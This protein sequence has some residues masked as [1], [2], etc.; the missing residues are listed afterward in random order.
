MYPDFPEAF[1]RTR[2]AVAL[3]LICV[4]TAA[5]RPLSGDGNDAA[6]KEA[7]RA[8]DSWLS[9]VDAGKY[10]ESWTDASSLFR[11]S[12]TRD[13]WRSAIESVRGPI[14]KLK[15]RAFQ[16]ATYSTSLPG[17]PDGAYVV[18]QYQ[19]AFEKKAS[20]VETVTPMREADG[21]WRVSGYFVK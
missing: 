9:L 20:A 21:T 3:A 14:G 16:S 7:R 2:S 18:I 5:A 12:V 6:K 13:Q 15:T 17:A 19:T 4:I 8:A 11:K 1:M 10:D